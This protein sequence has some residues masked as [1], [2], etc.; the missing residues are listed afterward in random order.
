MNRAVI[1]SRIIDENHRYFNLFKELAGSFAYDAVV[2][3]NIELMGECVDESEYTILFC[4]QE[5]FDQKLMDRVK[6]LNRC[7]NRLSV[8]ILY[9]ENSEPIPLNDTID[10][11]LLLGLPEKYLEQSLF[12]IYKYADIKR[13][14]QETS[15][16]KDPDFLKR[17][18][19]DTAHSIN[20]I[21]TGMQG[22]AELA[23]LNP[24]E[25]QL[26]RDSFQVVI[27][28]SN[29]V[30]N[31]IKNLR[32]FARV[33][34]PV[35]RQIPISS[36]LM[37]SLELAKNQIRI[38]KIKIFRDEREEFSVRGDYD[39]LVQ[40]FF[41]LLNEVIQSSCP[42]ARIGIA[43]STDGDIGLISITCFGYMLDQRSFKSLRE[44][45]ALNE[46][47]LKNQGEEGKIENRNVLSICNRIVHKHGGSIELKKGG[48]RKFTYTVRIPVLEVEGKDVVMGGVPE[49]K[50]I[51]DI[52]NLD[53]DI[54]IVDDEEYIRNTIYYYFNQKGCR[55]TVAENGAYGL[56]IARKHPFDIIFMDYLMPNMGGVEAARKILEQHRDAKIVFIT[57][58][59]SIDEEE[60]Y[61]SGIY[62]CIK[63]PF[64]M[65][66]LLN[67]TLNVAM[68]RGIID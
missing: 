16:V 12:F 34:N 48:E 14:V 65:K 8:V 28:S 57:G 62:A 40:V 35:F 41:N 63:K 10:G 32:A 49:V 25:E 36:V 3:P 58:K 51:R 59:E 64:E 2:T 23:L 45:F 68:Q 19:S 15:E 5:L 43:L 60:L 47:L 39:Q 31:E 20:N 67:I 54:L 17:L 9:G 52:T 18:F 42:E 21:L 44:L 37:D 24:H 7:K 50:E 1:Y 53:M 33:E 66:E 26:I 30:R 46:I 27:D 55:V 29:R 4:D 56:S 11:F 22:Y 13:R 61:K 38:K 6:K